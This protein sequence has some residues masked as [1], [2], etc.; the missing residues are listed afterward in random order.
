[1]AHKNSKSVPRYYCYAY[2]YMCVYIHIYMYHGGLMI[3]FEMPGLQVCGCELWVVH[4]NSILAYTSVSCN[5]IFCFVL[6]DDSHRIFK[7]IEEP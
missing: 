2:G 7:G 5:L 3:S 1:M 4:I 6:L